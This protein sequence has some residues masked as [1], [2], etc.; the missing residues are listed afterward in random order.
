MLTYLCDVCR[1]T[2]PYQLIQDDTKIGCFH[3]E[4][5][6]QKTIRLAE[7]HSSLEDFVTSA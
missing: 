2:H 7:W 3:P 4:E 6:T 1:R 5:R